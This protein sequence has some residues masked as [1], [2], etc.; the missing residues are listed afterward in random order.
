MT[1]P[2]LTVYLVIS[3]LG[4]SGLCH[5]RNILDCV[6]LVETILHG[7]VGPNEC[8][9]HSVNTR[10]VISN[11]PLFSCVIIIIS[12]D[13]YPTKLFIATADT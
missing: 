5:V 4:G 6:T 9:V 2:L 3:P 1:L 8:M 10:K 11:N 7:S 12:L 13:R